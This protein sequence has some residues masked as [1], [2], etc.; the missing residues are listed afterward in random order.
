MAIVLDPKIIALDP[1]TKCGW[2][3][4]DDPINLS[5]VWDCSLKPNQSDYWRLHKL[6]GHIRGLHRTHGGDVL[7]FEDAALGSPGRRALVVAGEIQGVIKLL[8]G[9]LGMEYVAFANTAIKKFA[10][11]SGGAKKAA[12]M[13]AARERWPNVKLVDDNHADALWV[14]QLALAN[15]NGN[16]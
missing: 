16:L 5:G 11:G 2:A 3:H 6:V 14:M 8:A 12:M 9:E 13:A 1:A 4:S 7:A 15:V 10:T